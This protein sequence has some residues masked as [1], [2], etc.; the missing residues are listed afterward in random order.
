MGNPFKKFP[1]SA[2]TPRDPDYSFLG[3]PLR[4]QKGWDAQADDAEG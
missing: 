3:L 2:K 4:K 1:R